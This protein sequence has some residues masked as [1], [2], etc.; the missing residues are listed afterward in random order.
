MMYINLFILFFLIL[1][2]LIITKYINKIYDTRLLLLIY[3][4][5]LDETNFR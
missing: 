4:F 2:S 1:E 3:V 5:K